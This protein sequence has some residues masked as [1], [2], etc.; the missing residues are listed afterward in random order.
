M[1][2]TPSR[3]AVKGHHATAAPAR[4]APTRCVIGLL[5]GFWAAVRWLHRSR[6]GHHARAGT[7]NEFNTTYFMKELTRMRTPKPRQLYWLM[8]GLR[9]ERDF[10]V[11]AI[12]A[13]SKYTAACRRRSRRKSPPIHALL[14]PA[15]RLGMTIL[16]P[17]HHCARKKAP[18]HRAIAERSAVK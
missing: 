10:Y 1:P 4:R 15:H 5:A 13:P 12:Q 8:R 18:P 14:Q 11:V 17:F 7:S 9:P 2:S 3:A 6:L 16:P